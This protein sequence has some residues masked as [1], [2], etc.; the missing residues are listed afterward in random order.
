[1]GQVKYF[2]KRQDYYKT[3]DLVQMLFLLGVVKNLNHG[4]I[5][6]PARASV[7][8]N[9]PLFLQIMVDVNV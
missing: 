8:N 1:M 4:E 6:G 2:L 9:A 3:V 7:P 5:P